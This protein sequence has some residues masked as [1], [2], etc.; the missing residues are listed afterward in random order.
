M[1]EATD[2]IAK[3]DVTRIAAR[4][5]LQDAITA[6]GLPTHVSVVIM[7]AA[8]SYGKALYVEAME[9][10]RIADRAPPANAG[11][12]MLPDRCHA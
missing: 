3:I 10:A 8:E 4:R 1:G 5:R 11:T 7:A 12:P 2:C 6:C 9:R